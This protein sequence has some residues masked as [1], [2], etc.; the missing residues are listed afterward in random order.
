MRHHRPPRIILA[1]LG[2]SA[3]SWFVWLR[4]TK[5]AQANRYRDLEL[6]HVGG[7]NLF[8]PERR[9]RIERCW[10]SMSSASLTRR[11]SIVGDG[12]TATHES[13]SRENSGSHGG[14]YEDYS[15]LGYCVV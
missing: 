9:K 10:D 4:S 11:R 1:L 8:T 3:R 6:L 14:E 7:L 2:I 12:M 15:L 5:A 13:Y